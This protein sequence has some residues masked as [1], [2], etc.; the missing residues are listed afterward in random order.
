M[1]VRF[2]LAV[3]AVLIGMASFAGPASAVM[4]VTQ[5]P[6]P[7]AAAQADA[8][9]DGLFDKA[10]TDHWQKPSG[11]AQSNQGLGSFHFTTSGT[12]GSNYGGPMSN[13]SAYDNAKQPGSEFYQPLQGSPYPYYDH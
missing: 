1:S 9:P 13:P 7:N 5:M 2:S 11:D 10:F 3:A 8:P 4:Q 12:S 6:D